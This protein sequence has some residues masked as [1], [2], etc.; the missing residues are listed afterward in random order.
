MR[1]F[2][3]L[4][5]AVLVMFTVPLAS[6]GGLLSLSAR[7]IVMSISAAVGFIS[8]MGVC[9]LEG[10]LLVSRI[11]HNMHAEGQAPIEAVIHAAEL[12]M[13]P[14]L[15]VAMTAV[16]GLLPMALATGIGCETQR[17]LA[18]V[19]VGGI[20]TSAMV[21]LLIHPAIYYLAHRH[22]HGDT[23]GLSAWDIPPANTAGH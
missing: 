18:T 10:V 21:N 3:S 2:D 5:D 14:V 8:L 22:Q 16:F 11:R 12:R 7:G 15:M 17:P 1:T 20:L 6:I 23:S 13:R 19:V 4:T 9:I